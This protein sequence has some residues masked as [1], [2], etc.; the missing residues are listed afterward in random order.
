MP[1]PEFVASSP[2]QVIDGP[3]VLYEDAVGRTLANDEWHVLELSRDLTEVDA[4]KVLEVRL[5]WN[6]SEPAQ[7]NS[8][9]SVGC[10][11][12]PVG[13]LLDLPFA[14][15]DQQ[16][17]AGAIPILMPRGSNTAITHR[18][19]TILYFS[20]PLRSP[21]TADELMVASNHLSTYLSLYCRVR[22][23]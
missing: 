15:H 3:E 5:L 1:L 10:A 18:A 11:C 12:F 7:G 22:L 21:Q 20:R 19:H 8:K 13:D 9:R 2:T 16:N 6:V 4:S 23:L 14:R 17:S